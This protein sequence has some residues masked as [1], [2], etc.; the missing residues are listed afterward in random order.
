MPKVNLGVTFT[1]TVK[2]EVTIEH[3][4]YERYMRYSVLHNKDRLSDKENTELLR[5]EKWAFAFEKKLAEDSLLMSQNVR[6]GVTCEVRVLDNAINLNIDRFE[7]TSN[8]TV[9][10]S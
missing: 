8:T 7:C 6:D 4:D 3:N 1:T 9:L 5:L 2:A 10:N